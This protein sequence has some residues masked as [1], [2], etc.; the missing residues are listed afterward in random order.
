M[1]RRSMLLVAAVLSAHASDVDAELGRWSS[2]GPYTGPVHSLAI[3][4]GSPRTLYA[5]TSG[6]VFR[7]T[8]SGLNWS[9]GARGLPRE[10]IPA[11][12][13]AS[14]ASRRVYVGIEEQV[15][16]S[17]DSGQHW[18]RA[19]PP[20]ALY[21]AVT[22]L[23]LA[24]GS[25]N[26]LAVASEASIYVSADAGAT[27]IGPGTGTELPAGLFSAVEHAGTAIYVGLDGEHPSAPG[28]LV[29][30]SLDNGVSWQATTD[31][32]GVGNLFED[33]GVFE[34]AASP[35]D[36]NR[37]FVSGFGPAAYS[38]DAGTTW[39]ALPLP[40]ACTGGLR[41]V[42]IEPS[43]S[44]VDGLWVGC[45]G[46]GLFVTSD[47]GASWTQ[48]SAGLTPNATG[49]AAAVA[50]VLPHPTDP[51]RL[52]VG[53]GMAGVYFT[54]S[55][56]L[57]WIA[58]NQGLLSS[59]HRTVAIHPTNP[60]VMWVGTGNA[61]VGSPAST[62]LF[63]TDD[64]AA[65]WLPANTG[66]NAEFIRDVALDP[67]MAATPAT[68]HLYAVGFAQS[69][70]GPPSKDGGIYKSTNGGASW[71]TIDTGIKPLPDVMFPNRRPNMRA[72]RAI[73]LDP[74]SCAAPPPS[75]PCTSGPLRTLY[76]GGQGLTSD[77]ASGAGPLP[78]VSE[79]LYK[80]TDA[81]ATWTPSEAGLPRP[82]SD[83]TRYVAEVNIFALAIDPGTPST[84]YAGT[85]LFWDPA[86]PLPTIP[87]GVFKSIDGGASWTHASNGLPTYG[88][89]GTSSWD[90]PANG[91]A[92]NPGNPQILYVAMSK[93]IAPDLDSIEGRI[94]KSL[95]GGASWIDVSS[96]IYGRDA[97][98]VAID[99]ADPSGNTVYVSVVGFNTEP[100]RVYKTVDGGASWDSISAGLT[101]QLPAA[102]HVVP[103]NSARLIGGGFPG[104]REFTQV[105]DVDRDDA[106]DAAENAGPA[107]ATADSDND[108][109]VD[110][111]DPD[112]ATLPSSGIGAP[113]VTIDVRPAA[114]CARLDA[115]EAIAVAELPR[116]DAAGAGATHDAYGA[117]GFDLPLCGSAEVDVSFAGASFAS[118][119]WRWRNYGPT[120]PGD[121]R[122][123]AWYDF[124]GATRL[125]AD[126]WRL[127][128]AASQ[129][130]S[131]TDE[132]DRIVFVGGPVFV[133]DA[134]F[135]DQFE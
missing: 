35:L 60:N 93:F 32:A 67:T 83:G 49:D 128:L 37:V 33:N 101:G 135:A 90:V 42:S 3:D 76:V 123:Y 88:G 18:R 104:V 94:Y 4:G 59:N 96:G 78:Y 121:G 55:G 58:V 66:L 39:T 122:T 117:I 118:A 64:G 27:W 24:P 45:F 97:R 109:V 103:G 57:G 46:G 9:A 54:T 102:L 131:W 77:P 107:G 8:D 7:S 89:A 112:T 56:G 81:G 63:R 126:T 34:L 127:T 14:R 40:P 70:T 98:A 51:L 53:T 31:L 130:G 75:G 72:V 25:E 116:D 69:L 28:K 13:V 62:A 91:L 119:E 17:D 114:G 5:V 85:L 16:R 1:A 61:F 129:T 105:S 36:A 125:D 71:T 50:D 29:Y 38:I 124:A 111:L 15:F 80:S 41:V 92:V 23:S 19:S 84:L 87:S 106:T 48:R 100:A 99:P 22:D 95:N 2:N 21:D 10:G 115:V 30:R 68:T 52:W 20:L 79:R 12:I 73:V 110:R 120:T 43:P 26:V 74:R 86:D 47:L 132:A 113:Y 133:A 6:G 134:I 44:A 82:I 108:G 65:T 11:R